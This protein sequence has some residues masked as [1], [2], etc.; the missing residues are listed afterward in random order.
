MLKIAVFGFYGPDQAR[1]PPD[2]P[3]HLSPVT[4]EE[5][6]RIVWEME[7]PESRIGDAA[8]AL[9]FVKLTTV[10]KRP[11]YVQ[12]L[13][14][15]MAHAAGQLDCDGYIAI[16]D[17]VK[18]LAPKMIQAALRRLDELHPTADLIIA[19]GRQNEPDALSSEEIRAILGLNA[20]L[21]VMPYVPGE[22]KTVHRLIRRMVRYI[23]NP[24]RVPPPVFPEK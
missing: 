9:G 16:I 24:D 15:R 8:D 7:P 11:V 23:D 18:I 1:T 3:T 21:L 22:P 5:F 6:M 17:A 19:A 14:D 2:R 10:T 20:A 4:T 12:A 13:S